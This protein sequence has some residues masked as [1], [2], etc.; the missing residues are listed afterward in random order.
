MECED[1]IS[2]SQESTNFP[3]PQPDKSNQLPQTLFS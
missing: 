2:C 1:L 3:F